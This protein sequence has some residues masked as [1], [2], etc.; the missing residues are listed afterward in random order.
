MEL[1]SDEVEMLTQIADYLMREEPEPN[2]W[3][4]FQGCT[5][6]EPKTNVKIDV[7]SEKA[8]EPHVESKEDQP[9]VLVPPPSVPHTFE[10]LR[11][12]T[13]E[14]P[15]IFNDADTFVLDVEITIKSI[16]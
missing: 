1:M 5:L 15:K 9:I 16:Y 12:V 7:P 14:L 6:Y 10:D 3:T 8:D 2:C 4:T 11:V 13:K